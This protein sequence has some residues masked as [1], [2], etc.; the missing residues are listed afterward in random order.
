MSRTAGEDLEEELEISEENNTALFDSLEN[1]LKFCEE[2]EDT[3]NEVFVIGGAMIYEE[4]DKLKSNVKNVFETRIG[5]NI[6]GDVKLKK[7]IFQ[8]FHHSEIS[9]TYSENNIN[10]DYNRYINPSLY[11]EF[12]EEYNRSVLESRCQ[13]YEYINLIDNIL[14]NGNIFVKKKGTKK[15]TEQAL[16]Q[17]PRLVI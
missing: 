13:E 5:Q 17:Y 15:E 16:V 1:A 14:E 4:A 12:Y 8:G 6:E 11:G 9:K 2:N 7:D 10:F 3:I